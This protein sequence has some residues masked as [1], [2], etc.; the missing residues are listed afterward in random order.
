MKKKFGV[1]VV[2]FQKIS[3]VDNS[4]GPHDYKGLLFLMGLEDGLETLNPD[5]LREMCLMSL[6]DFKPAEAAKFVLSHLFKDDVTN[7]TITEGKIDQLSQQMAESSLWEAY[8]DPSFHKRFFDAYGLLREAF[9]GIFAQPTGVR[10]TVNI[11][12]QDKE[13][14]GVFEGSHQPALV[15][16]LSGGLD[17][18]EILNRLYNEQL[19]GERFEEARSILWDSQEVLHTDQEVRYEVISSEFWF[20][21]LADVSHFEAETHADA[22]AAVAD[23]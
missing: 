12:S 23:E 11:T 14:F 8:S 13:A 3:G 21:G 22:A 19:A 5:E 2:S 9:N 20:G 15:R 18:G 10:F 17:Q 1:D 7:E 6:N 4:W 16:L